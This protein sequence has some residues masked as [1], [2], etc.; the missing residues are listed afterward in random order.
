MSASFPRFG[1]GPRSVSQGHLHARGPFDPRRAP[2]NPSELPAA[3]SPQPPHPL[4]Y[5]S[6]PRC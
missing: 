3:A 4:R 5:G 1:S 6:T 2:G